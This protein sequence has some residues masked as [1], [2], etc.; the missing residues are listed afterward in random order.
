MWDHGGVSNIAS[1]RQSVQYLLC[2]SVRLDGA[3]SVGRHWGFMFFRRKGC[4]PLP[5]RGVKWTRWGGFF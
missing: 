2:V 5:V 1:R 3:V 4:V